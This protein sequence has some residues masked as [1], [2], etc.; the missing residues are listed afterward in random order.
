MYT[1]EQLSNSGINYLIPIAVLLCTLLM[2]ALLMVFS[3][4]LDVSERFFRFILRFIVATSILV[5]IASGVIEFHNR[6]FYKNEVVGATRI[7]VDVQSEKCG[8]HSYCARGYVGYQID[9]TNSVI[10]LN[11]DSTKAYPERA[12]FYKN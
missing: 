4:L 1:V 3:V 2:G 9:G 5:P 11:I 6:P 12:V 7:N 10:Y 8:K